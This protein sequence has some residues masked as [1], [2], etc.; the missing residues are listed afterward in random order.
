MIITGDFIMKESRKDFIAFILAIV[1]ILLIILIIL[2]CYGI[3][4]TKIQDKKDDEVGI[5]AVDSSLDNTDISSKSDISKI[6][7]K[8]DFVY[9]EKYNYELNFDNVKFDINSIK[10]VININNKDVELINQ[11]IEK[12]YKDIKNN[13]ELYELNYNKY[14][15]N[16]IL[17]IVIQKVEKRTDNVKNISN[18]LVYNIDLKTGS[19]ISNR[20][21]IDIKN[22]NIEKVCLELINTI[23]KDLKTNYNFNISDGNF[24]IDNKKTA[25]DYIKEEIYKEKDDNL[26]KNLKMYINEKGKLCICFYVPILNISEKYTYSTFI[27]NI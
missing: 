10:P 12:Y 25:E 17:S 5:Y 13:E 21:L 3:F 4:N 27:L 22:T 8:K 18:V 1:I 14:V 11:E 6:D 7:D 2:V 23:S 16:N 9:D 26:G 20:E 19:D 24:L 15:Y